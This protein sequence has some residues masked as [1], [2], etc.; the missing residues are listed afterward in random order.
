MNR[1][2]FLKVSGTAALLLS[3]PIWKFTEY[4]ILP[5]EAEFN[6]RVFRGTRDG[7]IHIS[8]DQKQTWKKQVGFGPQYSVTRMFTDINGRLTIQMEFQ[9]RHFDLTLSE[10]GTAWLVDSP[11]LFYT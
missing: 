3:F 4:F 1:R 6:G 9:N 7:E 11:A 10:D 2:D 8:E 5:V